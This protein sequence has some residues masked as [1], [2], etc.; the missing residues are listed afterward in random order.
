MFFLNLKKAGFVSVILA[1]WLVTLTTGHAAERVT[2][3]CMIVPSSCSL[4]VSR[5]VLFPDGSA[6]ATL[7]GYKVVT[8][9]QNTDRARFSLYLCSTEFGDRWTLSDA[10]THTHKTWMS[11]E[12][13]LLNF[14]LITHLP[15]CNKARRGLPLADEAN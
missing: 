5:E 2:D 15:S 7:K 12:A 11:G 8:R 6:I 10:L 13:D 4:G 1:T 3:N 14:V 9:P